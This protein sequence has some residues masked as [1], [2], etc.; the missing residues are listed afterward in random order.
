VRCH[1]PHTRACSE[2]RVETG[3]YGHIPTL[4]GDG[5]GDG[6]GETAG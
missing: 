4:D 5:D 6:D 1:L 2:Q 3:D